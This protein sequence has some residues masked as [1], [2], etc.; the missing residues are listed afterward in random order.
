LADYF[1]VT[2]S[3]ILR[4]IKEWNDTDGKKGLRAGKINGI[5]R[6]REKWVKEYARVL[7]A[8]ELKGA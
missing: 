4:W 5:Y 7:Y 8:E 6:S 3:T 2:E 1:N